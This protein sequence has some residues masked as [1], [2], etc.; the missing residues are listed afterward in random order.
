[1]RKSKLTVP[2]L[3]IGNNEKKKFKFPITKDKIIIGRLKN[4]NDISLE[5]DSQKLVTRYM[6]CSIELE[7]NSYWIIDNASKNGTFI[8]KDEQVKKIIGK[9]K[10]SNNDLI[11]ILSNI[12][13]DGNPNYWELDFKDP[14]STNDAKLITNNKTLEYDWIQA[15]LFINSGNHKVEVKGLTLQEHK[16]IRFM[17]QKNKSNGNISVMCSFEEIIGAVWEDIKIT[18]SKNDVNHLIAALR[19]KLENDPDDPKFLI[20]IRG[21]GYRLI[22]SINIL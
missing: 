20:S 19:K 22:T 9:E 10:L 7:N 6:H 14:L 3:L 2:Y 21:M 17:Y 4:S 5:P 13:R 11:L 18:R 8:K 12:D 15:K 16:L 1:M